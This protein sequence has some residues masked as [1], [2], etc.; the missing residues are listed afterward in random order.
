MRLP[1]EIER[2]FFSGK[3]PSPKKMAEWVKE[4]YRMEEKIARLRKEIDALT[5]AKED[6]AQESEGDC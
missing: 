4:T 3:N 5:E 6:V 2:Q 1:V